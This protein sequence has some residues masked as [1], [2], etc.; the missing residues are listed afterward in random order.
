LLLA[1]D[2]YAHLILRTVVLATRTWRTGGAQP[3]TLSALRQA[4]ACGAGSGG[5]WGASG[6][7]SGL[8]GVGTV[9]LRIA[10][11][12]TKKYNLWKKYLAAIR[13]S[14]SVQCDGAC[15][16]IEGSV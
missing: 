10:D 1:H 2:S 3:T 8:G 4:A 12:L 14:R 7:L 6:G 5:S 16:N 13:G 9:S 15:R 11:F